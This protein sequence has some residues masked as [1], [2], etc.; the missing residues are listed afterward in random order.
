[1]HSPDDRARMIA[2]AGA[3]LRQVGCR[4]NSFTVRLE[5]GR[6]SH[7][8]RCDETDALCAIEPAAPRGRWLSPLE[9]RILV[10]LEGGEWRS[11]GAL[12]SLVGCDEPE[13]LKPILT[14]LV[15]RELLESAPGKGYKLA[16]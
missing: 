14:N 6:E 2:H 13:R 10:A 3:Y 15:D 5:C 9:E 8:I 7:T 4:P 11:S 1:M 16:S 12:A